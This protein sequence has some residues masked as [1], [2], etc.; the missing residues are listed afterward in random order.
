MTT[1]K[2]INHKLLG[3]DIVDRNSHKV[4]QRRPE[5]TMNG[6]QLLNKAVLGTHKPLKKGWV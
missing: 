4:P 5:K 1:K 3:G 2:L 6:E